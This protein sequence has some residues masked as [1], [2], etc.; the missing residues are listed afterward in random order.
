MITSTAR[1]HVVRALRDALRVNMRQAG[2]IVTTIRNENALRLLGSTDMRTVKALVINS[3]E[4]TPTVSL[5]V[6][7]GQGYEHTGI[8]LGL[9]Y[10]DLDRWNALPIEEAYAIAADIHANRGPEMIAAD[11]RMA[12]EAAAEAMND[13]GLLPEEEMDRVFGPIPESREYEWMN[14]T[15]RRA[16]LASSDDHVVTLVELADGTRKTMAMFP[17]F[18]APADLLTYATSVIDV[19]ARLSVGR[20]N[21]FDDDVPAGF[22][23]SMPVLDMVVPER[24]VPGLVSLHRRAA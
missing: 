14:G 2:E 18:T 21:I 19:P 23:R 13:N 17:L 16:S 5:Y 7:G 1:K 12:A 11:D 3:S 4:P 6:D 24:D 22:D 15:V 9:V 10:E 8:T 20:V